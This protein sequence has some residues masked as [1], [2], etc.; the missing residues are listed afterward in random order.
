M[1]THRYIDPYSGKSKSK[2]YARQKYGKRK[3]KKLYDNGA[4]W[5]PW[6]I[7]RSNF[8][9]EP[10]EAYT[11]LKPKENAYLKRN[12]RGRRSRYF[13]T[14]SHRIARRKEV[15]NTTYHK[16]FDFWWELD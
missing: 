16:T 9:W 13:K 14:L 2:S 10:T 12:W 5:Q 7:G 8:D 4:N 3:L 11:M 6:P 15:H 1:A